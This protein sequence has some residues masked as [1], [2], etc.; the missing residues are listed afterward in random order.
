M[1]DESLG[2]A[3]SRVLIAK[4]PALL[5]ADPEAIARSAAGL[6][7]LIGCVP[8]G[9]LVKNPLV[10]EA[11]LAAVEATIRRHAQSTAEKALRIAA[12]RTAH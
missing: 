7:Q 8:A 12:N 6:A 4:E 9:V 2:F 1:S 10:Y 11:S 5:V 3:L